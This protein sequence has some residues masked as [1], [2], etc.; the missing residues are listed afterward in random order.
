MNKY[1]EFIKFALDEISK[2]DDIETITISK[3][4]GVIFLLNFEIKF[5]KLGSKTFQIAYSIGNGDKYMPRYE[6]YEDIHLRNQII[7]QVEKF[8]SKEIIECKEKI[9]FYSK[10]LKALQKRRENE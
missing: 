3:S 5:K 2:I 10:K 1:L 9:E 6:R 7:E 8:K 4:Y